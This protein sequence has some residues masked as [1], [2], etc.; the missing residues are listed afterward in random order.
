MKSYTAKR[1]GTALELKTVT[2]DSGATYL[3]MRTLRGGYHVFVEVQAKE[4][5]EDCGMAKP[6]NTQKMW[7]AIWDRISN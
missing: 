7:K 1:K 4:V 5:A 6:G 3:V 2:G